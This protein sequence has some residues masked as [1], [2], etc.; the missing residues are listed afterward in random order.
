MKKS[1]VSKYFKSE[2]TI[3]PK[4]KSTFSR[5]FCRPII[6]HCLLL[7][8]TKETQRR[9]IFLFKMKMCFRLHILLLY[10]QG[11]IRIKVHC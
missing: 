10:F 8:K 1:I 7:W 2:I 5:F 9:D 11:Q 6:K 4:P 3:F